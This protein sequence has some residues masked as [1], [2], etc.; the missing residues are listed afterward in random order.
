[1]CAAACAGLRKSFRSL[2]LENAVGCH[3]PPPSGDDGTST[4]CFASGDTIVIQKLIP[5]GRLPDSR[6]CWGRCVS[7]DSSLGTQM[8]LNLFLSL[9]LFL[10]VTQEISFPLADNV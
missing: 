10:P 9:K 1:M 4:V 2:I 6:Q 8:K 3:A 5:N 7:L